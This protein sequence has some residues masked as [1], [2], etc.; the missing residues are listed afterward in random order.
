MAKDLSMRESFNSTRL[1]EL[2]YEDDSPPKN[3]LALKFIARTRKG[4]QNRKELP[5]VAK[6]DEPDFSAEPDY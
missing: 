5:K 3:S 1:E 4:P 6:P 2:D